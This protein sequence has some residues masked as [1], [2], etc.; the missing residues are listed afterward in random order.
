MVDEL[1]V[2]SAC[3]VGGPRLVAHEPQGVGESLAPGDYWYRTSICTTAAGRPLCDRL[4]SSVTLTPVVVE[5]LPARPTVAYADY[6]RSEVE[7][8]LFRVSSADKNAK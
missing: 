8:G 7:I 4:E 3:G 1:P 5:S 6:D 2:Y